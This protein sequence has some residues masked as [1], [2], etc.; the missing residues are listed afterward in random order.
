[1]R[2]DRV[3]RLEDG[4]LVVIDYKSGQH[5]P[6]DA[7]A[8]RL[9][10]PQLPA[11]ALSVGDEVAAVV[12]L[13]VGRE[14]VS[15]SGLADRAD[16]VSRIRSVAGGDAGWARLREQWRSRLQQLIAEALAGHA[17]VTPQPNACANC[18]LPMLCRIDARQAVPE[19]AEIA[20][21]VLEP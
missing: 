19:P 4:R 2:L 7:D 12:A 6:F 9:T 16:R 15:V 21:A 1:M 3:D 20:E 14:A 18:H 5:A 11:Y 17:A 10:Q 8:E 13:Y